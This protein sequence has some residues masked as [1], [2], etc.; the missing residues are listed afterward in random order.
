MSSY[1]HPF[2]CAIFWTFFYGDIRRFFFH[3]FKDISVH[4]STTLRQTFKNQVFMRSLGSTTQGN[5]KQKFPANLKI[6]RNR[7][8]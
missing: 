8:D 4:N 3:I 7:Y 5:A 6:V 1:K 2:N